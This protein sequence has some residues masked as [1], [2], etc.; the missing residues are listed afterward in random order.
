MQ[1]IEPPS[2]IG[3]MR[4]NR[5]TRGNSRRL[6]QEATCA[7][8]FENMEAR[9]HD[10]SVE[11]SADFALYMFQVAAGYMPDE[12]D[13]ADVGNNT[14]PNEQVELMF[15]QIAADAEARRQHVRDTLFAEYEKFKKGTGRYASDQSLMDLAVETLLKGGISTTERK[16]R[17]SAANPRAVG[18]KCSL[19]GILIMA[20]ISF[21][22]A[23]ALDLGWFG[24]YALDGKLIA[25][26]GEASLIEQVGAMS[27]AGWYLCVAPAAALAAGAGALTVYTAG[28]GTPVLTA[29]GTTLASAYATCSTTSSLA[30]AGAQLLRAAEA[31][32]ASSMNN[33]SKPSTAG[34][35]SS[36][37]L[38]A[39]SGRSSDGSGEL[40]SLLYAKA[41][42]LVKRAAWYAAAKFGAPAIASGI[43]RT[44]AGKEAI[45][46]MNRIP[47]QTKRVW[48]NLVG[49]S[50]TPA[51]KAAIPGGLA[52]KF[53]ELARSASGNVAKVVDKSTNPLYKTIWETGRKFASAPYSWGTERLPSGRKPD[54][55]GEFNTTH[56]QTSGERAS[57]MEKA[58]QDP[59]MGFPRGS[60]AAAAAR[61]GEI[62]L[63]T[64]ANALP[65]GLAILP[66]I[67]TTEWPMPEGTR[68]LK[69]LASD[70]SW[71]PS[72]LYLPADFKGAIPS[73]YK[74][75]ERPPPYLIDSA[76]LSYAT[77]G[78][79]KP[80]KS[81]NRKTNAGAGAKGGSRRN[82]HKKRRTVK[83]RARQRI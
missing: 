59:V 75:W 42:S 48:A 49:A 2:R 30:G 61:A 76:I 46:M 63:I 68:F 79:D 8:V 20:M 70:G 25:K 62:E 17:D 33:G 40:S 23:D 73:G 34:G 5:R 47:G 74:I 16:Y 15:M 60:A 50:G 13:I 44:A 54:E 38:V 27:D 10:K 35:E 22:Q 65:T 26:P 78:S 32:V 12:I 69:V 51:A 72:H 58:G 80:A 53:N 66:E 11:K 3:T 4:A 37:A 36:T 28:F 6:G 57:A 52:V 77:S 82:R 41:T 1:R 67:G 19:I 31:T 9:V 71:T 7:A 64:S 29:A 14:Y 45:R 18:G 43:S 81:E 21:K 83:R 55:F 56:Y 39:G 24:N